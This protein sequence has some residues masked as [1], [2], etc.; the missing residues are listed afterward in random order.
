MGHKFTIDRGHIKADFVLEGGKVFRRLTSPSRNAILERNHEI[1]KSA[2]AVKTTSFGK[3]EYDI[4]ICDIPALNHLFPH[5]FDWGHPEQK[6]AKKAFA[7][8]PASA[9]YRLQ[10]RKRGVNL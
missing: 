10:E 7:R 3:L 8:S 1:R 4:P 6:W 9:P 5:L 2:D